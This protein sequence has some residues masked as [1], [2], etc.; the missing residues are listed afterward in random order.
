MEKKKSKNVEKKNK[1]IIFPASAYL[2]CVVNETEVGISPEVWLLK[3]GVS[4]MLAKQFVHK[5]FI[6]C[7]GEPALFIQQGENAHWLWRVNWL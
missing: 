7:L 2:V 3:L 6:S 5:S 1:M 4:C